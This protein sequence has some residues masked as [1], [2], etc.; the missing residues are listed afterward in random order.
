MPVQ[1]ELRD[2][3]GRTSVV[4]FLVTVEVSINSP[5]SYQID[6]STIQFRGEGA[7]VNSTSVAAMFVAMGKATIQKG[8]QL[9]YTQCSRPCPAVT[10]A[11]VR[12]PACLSR[13]GS[14]LQTTF[15]ICSPG[16]SQHIYEFCCPGA[17]Q[18]NVQHAHGNGDG[19]SDLQCYPTY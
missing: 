13:N 11:E 18:V 16:C 3:Q 15:S 7:V 19:C 12:Q 10:Y 1:A 9:G 5:A 6:I 14:G 8:V 17:G 4:D 2:A